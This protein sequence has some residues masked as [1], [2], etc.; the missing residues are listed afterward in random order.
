MMDWRSLGLDCRRV[1]ATPMVGAH[2]HHE[3]ELNLLAGG[4]LAYRLG[5]SVFQLKAGQLA[6]FWAALPHQIV[7]VEGPGELYWLTV[8]LASFL[9]F[10]LPEVLTSRV[11]HGQPVHAGLP[12]TLDHARFEG[13]RGDLAERSAARRDIVLL[14]VEARL[15]RLGLELGAGGTE[16]GP[17]VSRPGTLLERAEQMAAYVARHSAQPLRVSDV[18]GAAGLSAGRAMTLFRETFGMTIGEYLTR[19]RVA[20]AG[21][22]LVTTELA[23]LDVAFEAGFGSASRFYEA[24]QQLCGQTPRQYRSRVR[25]GAANS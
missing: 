2:R 23:V 16:P 22:L 10:R 3:V 5:G 13:W 14:E 15:R 11:L 9:G 19:C 17:P 8:P 12:Q 25:P 7:E 1:R 20:H 18:A 24:F 21:R 6:V 4:R